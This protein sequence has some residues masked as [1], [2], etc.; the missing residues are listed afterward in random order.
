MADLGDLT[1]FLKEGSVVDL[2]WLDV[3]EKEYRELDRLPKQ[4]YDFAPD[5]EHIWSHSDQPL[6]IVPNKDSGPK[7]VGEL[8]Q[9]HGKSA[10]DE[11]IQQVIKTARLALMQS[12]SL[13][14]F[15]NALVTR[16][17]SD[18]LREAKTVLAQVL[19]ERGLLGRYYVDAVDF[20]GCHRAKKEVVAF[21]KRYAS[22]AQFVVANDRCSGCMHNSGNTCA[23]FQ[24]NLVLEVP[25][26]QAL[27]EAIERSQA[28]KGKEVQAS[29]SDPKSRIK[30][31]YLAGDVRVV[32]KTASPKPTVDPVHAIR[33]VTE[34]PKVH[35]PVLA[36]KS[37]SLAQ[38]ELSW[39]PGR[40]ISGH[41]NRKAFDIVA[42]LRREMLKGYGE[43][44]LLSNLKLS[45]SVDDLRMTRE[46]W[47]PVFREAG[48]Y[49][50]VYSTQESFDDCHDG[51]DFLAKYNPQVKAI[52]AGGKCSG[53]IYSKLS[54]CMLYGRP[55]VAKTDDLYTSGMV[56]SVLQ[57]HR[58]AGRIASGTVVSEGTPV[59]SLKAMYRMASGLIERPSVSTRAYVEQAF[60]GSDHGHITAGLT[61]REVTKT[62]LRYA[63]EG[64]Y[65][66]Q[67]YEALVRRFDPRD[68]QASASDLKVVL[69]E[70]G[71]QGIYYV[72]PTVYDDYAKG[73]DEG[74][75]I[76]RAR[77]VPYLKIGPKC[78]SCVLQHHR[79]FCS[80]YAKELVVEPPYADKTAQQKEI[81]ASGSATE[82]R[83]DSLVN[84][85]KS[86]LAEFAMRSSTDIELSPEPSKPVKLTVELGGA[87]IEL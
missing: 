33:P 78:A 27:A 21:A 77:L 57:D 17:D 66:T 18:T 75:R 52:V 36:S 64:L 42:F 29:D 34:V 55:L 73:C 20:P 68:I 6:S 51:A 7:T 5:L 63:N 10:S 53:C 67:L 82:I 32:D 40:S 86:I 45:F 41:A 28:A 9:V 56:E 24:K 79:G 47:E 1:N 69:A 12:M 14:G 46:A 25:Y 39:D 8:S 35:L 16:F 23:V 71:L 37:R 60:R 3:D 74:S 38:D 87:E 13:D 76:H 72:D 44:A 49:G 11:V 84:N 80:K 61:K 50:A 59:E 54:R 81:L 30:A 2:G 83:L 58:L 4:N 43:K 70:Q 19:G 62:A 26:S 31:A 15:R 48:L 85:S 22:T 65:G